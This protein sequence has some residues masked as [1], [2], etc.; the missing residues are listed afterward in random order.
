MDAQRQGGTAEPFDSP[1]ALGARATDVQAFLSNGTDDA[2]IASLLQGLAWVRLPEALAQ[3]APN[4]DSPASLP[5]AYRL[6]KAFFTPASLLHYLDHLPAEG[7]GALP[8]EIP[9]LLAAGQV[10][11]ALEVAWRRSR[12]A[13][14][15]W[16]VG[17]CPE[18]A[19]SDGPRLLASLAIPIQPADLARLLP[20]VADQEPEPAQS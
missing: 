17:D 16:P 13:G 1:A 2:R 11:K 4:A 14:L 18:D 20:R 9:R 7:R 12:I 19:G 15:G 8:Q 10:Q 6:T 3:G 5:L